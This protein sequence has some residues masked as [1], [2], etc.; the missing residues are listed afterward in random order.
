MPTTT[1]RKKASAPRA[2][3]KR[4]A[5]AARPAPLVD[6]TADPFDPDAVGQIFLFELDGVDYHIPDDASITVLHEY[7]LIE[8]EKGRA[9]AMWWLF[10]EFLGEDGAEALRG[11]RGLTRKHL[12]DLHAA[13]L[14]V[15]TGPKA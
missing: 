12:Q 10:G 8:A 3:A 11:Y 14:N 5:P 15:I 9:A 7:V 2:A 4:T 6:L 13:C 1:A